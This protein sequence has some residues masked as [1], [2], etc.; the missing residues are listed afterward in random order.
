[1]IGHIT[2]LSEPS[3]QR[4]FGRT[5][6]G[7]QGYKYDFSQEF[8]VESYLHHQ[9]TKFTHTFDANTYLYITKA[10][11]Y[12]DLTMGYRSLTESMKRAT[13]KFLLIAFSGDWLFP[14]YQMK[15]IANAL[16]KNGTD[17]TYVEIQSDYGHDAFLLET[18]AMTKLI[19]AFLHFTHDDIAAINE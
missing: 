10:M 12:F 2:Y 7:G 4:K 14:P 11:D 9:G 5:L 15:E 6:K 3:M 8:Q 1:M 19:S 17:V 13:N 18:E 16:R